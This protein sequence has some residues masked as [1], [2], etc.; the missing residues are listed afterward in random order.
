MLNF[1]VYSLVHSE[2]SVYIE[3]R[4]DHFAIVNV[5]IIQILR[6]TR[7]HHYIFMYTHIKILVLSKIESKPVCLYNDKFELLEVLGYILFVILYS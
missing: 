3:R 7:D 2:C 1:R 5:K 6:L 4:T